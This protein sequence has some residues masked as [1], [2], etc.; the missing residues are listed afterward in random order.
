LSQSRGN[1]SNLPVA[2]GVVGA[3]PKVRVKIIDSSFLDGK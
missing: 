3:T 1:S 2:E